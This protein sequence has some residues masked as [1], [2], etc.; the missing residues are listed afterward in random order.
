MSTNNPFLSAQKQMQTA[1]EFLQGRFDSE[2]PKILTPDRVI[3]VS[4]PV[5]MDSGEVQVFSW[6][7]SQHNSARGP[8]KGGVRY[9]QDVSKEE[10]MALSMWMSIK[11]ATLDLPLGG[12]K[13]WII[14][15]PKKLSKREL[16]AL[17]RGWVEKL[18]KYIGPLDD[19]PA[20]DVNTN[21]EI[22]SWFVDEYSR[23]I[24]H[25]APGA[26]TGKPLAI[27]GSLGRDTA[28]A[29]GGLYV[30]EA[31]LKWANDSLKWKKVVIQG[32]GNAWLNMIELIAKSWAILIG[33]SDSHGGIYHEDGL[34]VSEIVRLKKE[35][36]SLQEYKHT[37]HISNGELLEL[38]CDIL[39]PAALENQIT[40]DNAHKINASLI[41]E[42]A[43]GP[44]TPDADE[45]L[46]KK[47]IAVI[48]DILANAWGV[49]VSYFEQVQNSMNYYWSREEVQ[50][51]LKLKMEKALEGVLRSAKEHRVMLR[52][53]AY[54]VALERI[55]EAMKIRS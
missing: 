25:W 33:T 12:G 1:Y 43:N 5:M 7:R 39:I 6:Y 27:G 13:G 42:L 31:Y 53:W 9:H 47:D 55:L 45:I 20:P 30:L 36:K 46:Y 21:G 38:H 15:D 19:V 26:F 14:V 34:D 40:S 16:E 18:Y 8:Y 23:L 48:P 3:E 11:C 32:A 41:M 50:E 29:Q 2:F 17:S 24:G 28:T 49:T 35:K 10:V 44:I 37:K 52:T 51:K 22:M 4:I 54:V